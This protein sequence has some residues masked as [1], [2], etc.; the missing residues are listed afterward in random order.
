MNFAERVGTAVNLIFRPSKVAYEMVPAWRV[1][2]A[3]YP[4]E[5]FENYATQGYSKNE[6]MFACITLWGESAATATLRAYNKRSK[7]ELPDHPLRRLIEHPNPFMSEADM[8]GAILIHQRIAGVSYWEKVRS[9]A[10]QVVQLW[11]LR[12]DWVKPIPSSIAG[13]SHYE[14]CVPGMKPIKLAVEDVLDFKLFDPVDFWGGLS[15]SKVAARVGNI[16]NAITDFLKLFLENGGVPPGLLKSKLKLSDPDVADIRRRWKDRYGGYKNWLEPA[17]LDMD[18]EYQKTGLDFREMGF[19]VLDA[20]SEARICSVYRVPPILVGAK[21]G[22]DKA[23]YSNY[24]EARKAFWQDAL[25]PAYKHL[26][27]ELYNDLASEFGED[28]DLRWDYSEVPALQEDKNAKWQRATA[29]FSA[30]F[31][32]AN[33]ARREVGLD[34]MTSG[35]LTI[36]QLKP[37]PTMPQLPSGKAALDGHEYKDSIASNATDDDQRRKHERTMQQDFEDFFIGQLGR[38]RKAINADA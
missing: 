22:L 23:T 1:Q 24:A 8:F 11:P 27:D 34:V 7:A 3:K 30:G 16:D 10:G 18:A 5:S 12:P 13:I 29:A 2:S 15:P 20:R 33:D 25:M 4:A 21:V 9:R 6:L 28:I 19:D 32:T 17:V 35:D 36:H 38:V 14:Y 26:R 37:A 31:I